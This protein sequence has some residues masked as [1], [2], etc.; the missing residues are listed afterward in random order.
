MYDVSTYGDEAWARLGEQI[1][2]RRVML[3]LTQDELAERAEVAPGTIR[4]YEAGRRGQLLKL[5]R[6]NRALGWTEDSY[7][8]VLD[9]GMPSVEQEIPAQSPGLQFPPRPEGIS[10]SDWDELV[11]ETIRSFEKHLRLYG[12]DR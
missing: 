4:N 7:I 1:R 12:R 9:G 2:R 8:N 3:G 11:A 6:V 10:E 5:P